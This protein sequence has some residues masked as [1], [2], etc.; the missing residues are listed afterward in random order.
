MD[1]NA[2]QNIIRLSQNEN[3]FGPSPMAME[4][5]LKDRD[6]MSCYPEPHSRT[7]N[8]K[9]A[10]KFNLESDNIFV[11][12]GLTEALDILIRNFIAKDENLVIPELTFVAYKML[13]KVFN[14]EA[15]LSKMNNFHIDVDDMLRLCDKKT[16]VLIIANPNNP[17][18]TVISEEE[19]VR[20]LD[21]V[22]ES[23]LVV[24]DEAYIEYVNSSDYPDCLMLQEKYHNLIIMRTFSKIYG[25]AG[26]RI[27]Y[28]I[29]TKELIKQFDYFQA[30]FTVNKL[31]AI[32]ASHALDDEDYV[33]M[34]ASSNLVCRENLIKEVEKMGF[35]VVPSESNFLFIHF[36]SKD[37]RDLVFDQIEAKNVM[38]RKMDMFGEER[39][40]RMTVGTPEMNK[41]VISHLKE[42]KI[43]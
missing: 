9:L 19:L 32:A 38:A 3:P 20:I 24:V 1:V 42:V 34:S 16:K 2:I 43:T 30:P 27:G 6:K 37:Q 11:C 17:T 21:N 7:L 4:A 12:A 18:G 14:K 29:A 13:A 36:D 26:L 31:A 41:T 28:T 25:L 15:R 39:A 10:A 22:P 23:T 35:K 33:N 8:R 40:F 5:V